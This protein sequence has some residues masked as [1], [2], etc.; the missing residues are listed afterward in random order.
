M[1]DS[2]SKGYQI[3]GQR[4][5]V[6]LS[7]GVA[8]SPEDALDAPGLLRAADVALYGAKAEGRGVCCRFERRM[9]ESRQARRLMEI[10]L[11]EAV[12]G[13]DFELFHHRL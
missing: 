10:E 7:V 13:D 3:D 8:F 6:G 11:R 12:E 5:N 9:D 2:V 4:V 1:I